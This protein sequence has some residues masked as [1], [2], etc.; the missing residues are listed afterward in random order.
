MFGG[1]IKDRSHIEIG[2]IIGECHCGVRLVFPVGNRAIGVF[3]VRPVRLE[4]DAERLAKRNQPVV[5]VNHIAGGRH[6]HRRS[7]GNGVIFVC[8]VVVNAGLRTRDARQVGHR[9]PRRRLNPRSVDRHRIGDKPILRRDITAAEEESVSRLQ[10]VV[11]RTGDVD[12]AV[13]ANRL[14]ER[15]CER[16]LRIRSEIVIVVVRIVRTVRIVRIVV[17]IVLAIESIIINLC[18]KQNRTLNVNG[19]GEEGLENHKT[20]G[21]RRP[22]N[23]YSRASI[24]ITS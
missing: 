3:R 23:I 10:L 19:D 1:Q 13:A 4:V 11:V 16:N 12:R 17:R 15:R 14:I 18:I 8:A 5:G 9:I 24:T 21:N 20:I 7:F 6:M 2:Q 22:L